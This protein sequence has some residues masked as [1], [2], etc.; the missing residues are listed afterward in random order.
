MVMRV[1]GHGW[2]TLYSQTGVGRKVPTEVSG[3]TKLLPPAHL[4]MARFAARETLVLH[5]SPCRAACGGAH[6]AL[7]R[8]DV[9]RPTWPFTSHQ[10]PTW[11]F[12]VSTNVL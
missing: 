6:R 7:S 12:T 1:M 8:S 10:Q 4:R 11:P 2:N 9:K 3:P 5:G